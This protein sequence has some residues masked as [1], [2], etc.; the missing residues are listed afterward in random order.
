MPR[1]HQLSYVGQNLTEFRTPVTIG[2]I[3]I[4]CCDAL[5]RISW[6]NILGSRRSSTEMVLSEILSLL[7]VSQT[8][9]LEGTVSKAVFTS[10][11]DFKFG[12]F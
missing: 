9:K 2:Q 8:A 10:D 1:H 5:R 11:T 6:L 12:D 4:L 7:Q 3:K